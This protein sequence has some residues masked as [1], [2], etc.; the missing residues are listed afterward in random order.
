[1]PFLSALVEGH[2]GIE[3]SLLREA[4][5]FKEIYYVLF[6][7]PGVTLLIRSPVTEQSPLTASVQPAERHGSLV[8]AVGSQ[9][10]T[11]H[12]LELWHLAQ[13]CTIAFAYATKAAFNKK[14]VYM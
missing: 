9:P 1:M 3:R 8:L 10:A 13:C 2:G 6:N 5:R 14:K 7:T 12:S 4:A 11:L